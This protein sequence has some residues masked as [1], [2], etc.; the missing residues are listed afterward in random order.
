M[1]CTM[2]P[3]QC[4]AIRDAEKNQGGFC[5]MPSAYRVARA[6]LHFWEEPC[7]SGA[8]GSGTVFFSGCVLKCVYCQ[9]YKISTENFGMELSEAELIAV[10]E[11]LIAQGAQNINLVNPTH[12]ALQL[13]AALQHWKSPVPVIYNSGGYERLETLHALE[14][15]VDV[16]LPDLKY[17]REAPAV[18]YSSA[19]GYFETAAEAVLEMARQTGPNRF[20]EAGLI[21]RGLIVRHLVLPGHTNSAKEI[22]DWLAVHLPKGNQVSLMAQYVPLGKAAKYPELNRRITAR[23][24]EKVASFLVDSGMENGYMQERSSANNCF[25]PDFDLTGMKAD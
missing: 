10:F 24:Y 4:G 7:I 21:T 6:A 18:A 12:Y 3:R 25:V 17:S 15:L 22:L 19:P 14:G 2:C 13:A 11:N 8:N 9:N 23:E 1:L 16:Y 20:N 5:G